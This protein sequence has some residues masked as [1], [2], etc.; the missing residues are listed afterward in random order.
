MLKNGRQAAILDFISTKFVLSYRCVRNYILFYIY[1]TDILHRFWVTQISQNDSNSKLPLISHFAI[2]C[3][4]K[5][6]RSLVDITSLLRC[7]RCCVFIVISSQTSSGL[8]CT[9]FTPSIPPPM[10]TCTS[11]DCK[12][13]Q[14]TNVLKTGVYYAHNIIY[15]SLNTP[16]SLLRYII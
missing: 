15:N 14:D 2:V 8:I 10:E 9:M 4:Q 11:S 12:Q 6:M 13:K 3:C 1:D 16:I 5:L 7:V